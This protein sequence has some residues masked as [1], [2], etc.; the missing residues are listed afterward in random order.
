[1][2]LGQMNIRSVPFSPK[3][4]KDMVGTWL[5]LAMQDNTMF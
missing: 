2:Y 4:Q 3:E 1:M 5:R